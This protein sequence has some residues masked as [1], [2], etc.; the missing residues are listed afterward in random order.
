MYKIGVIDSDISVCQ[1]LKKNLSSEF[2]VDC[3]TDPIDIIQ[4]IKAHT[5]DVLLMD[6]KIPNKDSKEL[7]R[8]IRELNHEIA[9]IVMGEDIKVT[10][11][12]EVMQIGADDVMLKPLPELSI[13]KGILY[14]NIRQHQMSVE[15]ISLR[16]VN[17][18]KDELISLISH[19]FRTPLTIIKGYVDLLENDIDKNIF[20]DIND[21]IN[22]LL[23]LMNSLVLIDT[24]KHKDLKITPFI[25][26]EVIDQMVQDFDFKLRKK[27]LEIENDCTEQIIVL[28]ELELIKEVITHLV[29]NAVK[30]TN[31]KGKIT[32]QVKMIGEKVRISVIDN[33]IGID[34]EHFQLI[35]DHFKQVE[36]FMTR[37]QDGMGIGLY[38]VKRILEKHETGIYLE[39][40]KGKGSHFCFYLPLYNPS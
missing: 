24:L 10:E 23:R 31:D 7:L 37:Q 14:K 27:S 25:I 35:F 13:I 33:G 28:G 2:E 30:F 39:S 29:D 12:I 16:K 5:L 15:N 18:L 9:I 20:F 17:K 8:H 38:L 11:I 22:Q 34:Q 36:N 21:Q 3:F 1:G 19:E 26:N 32:I 4:R 6:T 40:K